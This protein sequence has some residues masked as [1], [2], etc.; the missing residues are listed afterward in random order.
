M[1]G[2]FLGSYNAQ[3]SYTQIFLGKHDIFVRKKLIFL[4]R[5]MFST[6]SRDA[7]IQSPTTILI[8]PKGMANSRS[9]NFHHTCTQ[10]RLVQVH[11]KE[12]LRSLTTT[13]H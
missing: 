7:L 8:R 11:F 9:F 12:S 10:N 1:F 6:S 2:A 13:P 4:L 3:I 5:H